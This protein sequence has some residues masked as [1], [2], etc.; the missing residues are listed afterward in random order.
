MTWLP[1]THSLPD[2]D[3]AVLIA[4]PDADEPVWIGYHDEVRKIAAWGV[5]T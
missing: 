1:V 5:R 3:A 2:A 4:C